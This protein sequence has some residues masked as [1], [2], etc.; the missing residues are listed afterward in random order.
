MQDL[1]IQRELLREII[2][3]PQALRLAINTE[4]GQRNQLLISNTQPASHVNAITQQRPFR[5]SN[6]RRNLKKLYSPNES[7]MPKLW[8]HLV[9]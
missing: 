2:E 7:T 1:Q 3:S 6:Q 8:P 9:R 4:L 5:Q